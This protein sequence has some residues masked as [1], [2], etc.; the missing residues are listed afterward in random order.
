MNPSP[1]SPTSPQ[2]FDLPGG[3]RL[4]LSPQRQAKKII[5]RTE[6]LSPRQFKKLRKYLQRRAKR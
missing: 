4:R 2:D 6:D 1:P 5:M 3:G